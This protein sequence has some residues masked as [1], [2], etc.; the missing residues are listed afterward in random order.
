MT[1]AS[2]TACAACEQRLEE[3]LRQRDEALRL[4][5]IERERANALRVGLSVGR[6]VGPAW[7]PT[8]GEPVPLRY[9]VV[10]AV[11]DTLKGQW[12]SLHRLGK[13]VLARLSGGRGG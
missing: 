8:D 5:A 3:A 10:D 4:L 1:K 13:G 6:S 11:N 9:A 7:A 2:D 12:S